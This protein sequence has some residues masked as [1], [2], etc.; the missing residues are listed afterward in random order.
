[1][2]DV[3]IK[4]LLKSVSKPSKAADFITK[5]IVVVEKIDGTKLTLIRNNLPFDPDDYSRNWI[6]AYK[7]NVIYPSEFIGLAGRDSEIKSTALGSSQYKFVHDHLRKVHSKTAHIPHN[8]EFFVEF[9]QNKPTI[10]RDYDLKHGLYLVG[11]G[12]SEYALTGGHLFSSAS[13]SSDL[14]ALELYRKTLQLS[15]FPVVFK[16][17]LSSKK[18]ILS[19]CIDHGLKTLFKSGFNGTDFSDPLSVVNLANSAFSKLQ[20]SL[21]G[22]AEGVVI[23]IEGEENL[24]KVLSAD[25]HSK[26]V[27]AAKKARYKGTEEEE[28]KYWYEVNLFVDEVLESVDFTDTDRFLGYLS[29]AVYGSKITPSHPVKSK[30]NVQE[31]LFL[32]AKLRVLGTG[33][34]GVSKIAVIP[35]AAKPYHAGH[36]SLVRK[37]I[38]DGN[39]SVVILVSTRGR[40][41]ITTEDMIP[42]WRDCYIPGLLKQYGT[43]LIIKFTDSPMRE[44]VLVARSFVLRGRDAVVR[45]YGGIDSSGMNEAQLRVDTILDKNPDLKHRVIA[46]GVKRS[47]TDDVSGTVMRQYAS[48]GDSAAFMKNLPVWLTKQD[49]SKVWNQCHR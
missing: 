48:S 21:G 17:S 22:P 4:P 12:S 44:T 26:E 41:E 8:T 29:Q 14:S 2:L 13:F 42:A 18:S 28:S 32:T 23:R 46:V 1:M 43:R 36:D 37:S 30:I 45:V 34:Q 35:M 38:E 11:F 39:D 24:L 3:S 49:K 10:T 15:S 5:N 6:V 16:G 25:Q 20:S 27:R 19:G 9:V 47:N 31:D 7:G 33:T 40:E